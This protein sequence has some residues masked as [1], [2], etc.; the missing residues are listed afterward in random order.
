MEQFELLGKK[1][2]KPQLCGT[3]GVSSQG[4]LEI[5]CHLFDTEC[6]LI[7]PCGDTSGSLSPGFKGVLRHPFFFF[8]QMISVLLTFE[9]EIF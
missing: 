4:P 1:D 2:T 5:F 7:Q 8:F 9:S 3:L 6:G